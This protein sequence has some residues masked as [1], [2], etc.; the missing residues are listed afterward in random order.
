MA[1]RHPEGLRMNG[2]SSGQFFA[3]LPVCLQD[4]HRCSS[5]FIAD[6][7][8]MD[9]QGLTFDVFCNFAEPDGEMV[10]ET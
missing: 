7:N 3:R 8:T 4:L 6:S 5:N 10:L 1:P 2:R 9:S